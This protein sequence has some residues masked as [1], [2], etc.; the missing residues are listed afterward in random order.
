MVDQWLNGA[1]VGCRIAS[2]AHTYIHPDDRGVARCRSRLRNLAK[3]SGTAA[4]D[5]PIGRQYLQSHPFR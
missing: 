4:E 2:D 3:L 5:E 1:R